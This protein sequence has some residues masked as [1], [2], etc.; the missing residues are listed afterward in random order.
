VIDVEKQLQEQL[1]GASFEN[2][3]D[4]AMESM[5]DLADG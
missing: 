3:F 1:S 4:S 2:V 5:Y